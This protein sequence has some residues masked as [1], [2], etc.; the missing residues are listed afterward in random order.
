MAI[1][2]ADHSGYKYTSARLRLAAKV[3]PIQ[4]IIPIASATSDEESPIG[5]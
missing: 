3:G 5:T 4:Q 1:V 2:H